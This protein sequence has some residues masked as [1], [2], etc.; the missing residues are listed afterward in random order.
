[1]D[2]RIPRLGEGADSGTIVSI[3]VKEGDVVRKDQTVVELENEKAVAPIPASDGG[4]VI[5]LLVKVGDKVSVGQAILT[6]EGG[7]ASPAA[8]QQSAPARAASP[9]PSAPAAPSA[10]SAPVSVPAPASGDYQYESKTGL[11]PPASPTI[12]RMA[13]DLGIDLRRVRGSE[14]GGRIVL[15]DLRAYIQG[16]QQAAVSAAPSAP[17]AAKTAAPAP[18]ESVDFSKWGPVTKKPL[19]SLRQKIAQKMSE[20]WQ[21]I[22]HVTQFDEADITSLLALRKKH[23]A[24]YEKKGAKLTV[25]GFILKAVVRA[26][27]K[28]PSFNSSLDEAA[29]ELVLKQYY[30][31]GVAVD[32]ESGLIVP[33]LKDVDKKSLLEI[34]KDLETLAEKTR[35]RKVGIDDLK[36]GS[37]TVSNLGGIGG[38]FFTPIVNRPEVAIL[39][40]GRGV[41]RPTAVDGK[42]ELRTM[43]PLGLSYDH[44]VIDG[45]DGARFIREIVTSLE[46]FGEDQVKI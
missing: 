31:L 45:A 9:V 44:R 1:M 43:L 24:A 5:K 20:S 15:S 21:A 14:H 37:F 35:S 6:L 30:H 13:A 22:P 10:P 19:S 12:R 39:G 3:L 33:V 46:S 25:T 42:V 2:I 38:T 4:K 8:S 40:V 29:Q 36:G 11:P 16:L 17:A 41:V 7:A 18:A 27:Q 34:S 23:V 32:T 28:H 26:L